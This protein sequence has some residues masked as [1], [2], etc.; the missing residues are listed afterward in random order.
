MPNATN[1]I[2]GEQWDFCARCDFQYPES[3]FRFQKGL[4]L[5]PQCVD[6]L[7]VERRDAQISQILGHDHQENTDRRDSGMFFDETEGDF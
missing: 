7:D 5:C 6:N 4:K 1:N 2:R 3:K